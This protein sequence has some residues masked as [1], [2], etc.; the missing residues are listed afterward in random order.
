M[1]SELAG[2]SGWITRPLEVSQVVSAHAD[3]ESEFSAMGKLLVGNRPWRTSKTAVAHPKSR[4][5][6]GP[7]G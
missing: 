4:L 2:N 7:S 5:F 3:A 1:N 6:S